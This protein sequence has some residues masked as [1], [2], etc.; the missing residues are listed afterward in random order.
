MEKSIKDKSYRRFVT[1]NAMY[2]AISASKI[3][4]SGSHATLFLETFLENDGR[5]LA[6]T[7]YAK[8]LCEE[9]K[10][11]EWRASLID[12]GWLIWKES[13][14]D[15]GLYFPGKKLLHYINKEK[16]AQSEL[17]TRS[18][19][20]KIREEIDLKLSAKADKSELLELKERMTK[21]EEIARRLEIAT[22]DPVT[23]EKIS[24]QKACAAEMRKLALVK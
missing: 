20:E 9:K 15:K 24:V 19:V 16:I 10:F 14:D 1:Y 18:S 17:A 2:K 12:K 21:F 6:S 7:V 22:G 23:D 8:G 11:R 13:Q 5:M 4:N 3:S